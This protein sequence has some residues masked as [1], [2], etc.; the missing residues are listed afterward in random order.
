MKLFNK[1]SFSEFFLLGQPANEENQVDERVNTPNVNPSTNKAQKNN[2]SKMKQER[3]KNMKQQALDVSPKNTVPQNKKVVPMNTFKQPSYSEGTT[4]AK[5]MVNTKVADRQRLEK[6][7]T[8]FEPNEY[9]E[10][11]MMAQCLFRNEIVILSFSAMEEYQ[12][13][14]VIDFLTGVVYAVDGDIQR[15][16]EEIFICTPQNVEVTSTIAKSLVEAHLSE[17]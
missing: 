11:R 10:C 17:M 8:V 5:K 12:A 16:G 6:K 3:T 1:Q 7:V 15:I 9:N 2:K 14:R 13:R 4:N